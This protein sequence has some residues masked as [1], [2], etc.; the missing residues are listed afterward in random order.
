MQPRTVRPATR[1]LALSTVAFA[2]SF[3]LWG[4]ISA[5]APHFKTLYHLTPTEKALM[6]AV[7]V[8]LG[9]LFRVPMGAL[10]DRFGGPEG[11]QGLAC[12]WDR[13]GCRNRLD[14]LVLGPGLLPWSRR[15][16]LPVFIASRRM[17]AVSRGA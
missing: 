14:A 16:Q 12:L 2:I 6:I 8:I 7:P 9:S 15:V 10:T 1:Q 4:L 3:A 5:L 11:V 17:P 13:A